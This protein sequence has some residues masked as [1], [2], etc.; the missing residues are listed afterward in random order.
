MTVLRAL[1]FIGDELIL[2][3]LEAHPSV[4]DSRL[5]LKS[6]AP[7]PKPIQRSCTQDSSDLTIRKHS[8]SF[9]TSEAMPTTATLAASTNFSKSSSLLLHR[10]S[11]SSIST[12]RYSPLEYESI[13]STPDHHHPGVV[14]IQGPFTDR[15]LQSIV[16]GIIYL[17]RLGLI[18]IVVV[19]DEG[20]Q[21]CVMD[22]Y[23]S[24]P[25]YKTRGIFS[26][27]R[28][29]TL[30]QSIQR[31]TFRLTKMF[32]DR[33][34]ET[35]PMIEGVLRLG[36]GLCEDGEGGLDLW[37]DNIPG[38]R[39]AI[40]N[41]EIP[42][43]PPIAI[44][45]SCA[46]VCIS[47]NE[48]VKAI[49]KGLAQAGRG[50]HQSFGNLR[51]NLESLDQENHRSKIHLS[52][53]KQEE[54]TKNRID[55]TPLRLMII[56]REGGIPSPARNGH[57][58]LSVNLASE[59]NFILETFRWQ[60]SHPSSLSNLSMIKSSLKYLPNE[61]SAVIVSHRSPKS[62]IA[63]LIT[64]KPAHSPSLNHAI[65]LNHHHGIG[66]ATPTLVRK[67]LPIKVIR[68]F[69]NIDWCKMS[70]LLEASFAKKL[71]V[72]S[73]YKRVKKSLSFVIVAGD[74][75]GAAIV[76]EEV[77][78]KPVHQGDV[79]EEK[80]VYLDK[81]AVLPSLQG[82]G[83]VDF[84][85]GALR[86]E[87][88]GL[89]SLDALNDNGGLGGIGEPVDLV[90][91]SRVDNPVNK[92]YWERSNGF[93]KMEDDELSEESFSSSS[94]RSDPK[95]M[96]SLFWCY[97]ERRNCLDPEG[98]RRVEGKNNFATVDPGRLEKWCQVIKK[99]PTCWIKASNSL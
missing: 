1:A 95:T 86:D 7:Q 2:S 46:T 83:I 58:H 65:L 24:R 36:D 47:A 61:S 12:E 80:I 6:F 85:W 94:S 59:Y 38:I 63:N 48:A 25:R 71:N 64:N 41:R 31:E 57:P 9:P 72:S 4:R 50:N 11:S 40:E 22:S 70:S 89:G 35:R 77:E 34:G 51:N 52:E 66:Q 5:Y 32:E 27:E 76:T 39:S 21:P 33:G 68:G 82:E 49:T 17:K 26:L 60:L 29:E 37:V 8:G 84:L 56:N 13:L 42:I 99:I 45:S 53:Q 15:Q 18:P 88:F 55:L 19:D 79:E 10:N 30:R 78:E 44:N 20:W 74:Y 90:W 69:E 96:F 98:Q 93:I 16:D 14:K 97:A 28:K 92:W 43:I 75:Q 81:F 73:F 87:T 23:Q 67:G 91:R 3:V 62:L 54:S